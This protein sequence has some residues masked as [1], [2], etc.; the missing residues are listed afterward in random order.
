MGL[1]FR[2]CLSAVSCLIGLWFQYDALW[3]HDWMAFSATY[4]HLYEVTYCL[5][6]RHGLLLK[7]VV[8]LG[9]VRNENEV[10]MYVVDSCISW[11]LK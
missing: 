1:F 10:E 3:V 6:D 4:W 7:F 9:A 5:K 11:L 2:A 8:A